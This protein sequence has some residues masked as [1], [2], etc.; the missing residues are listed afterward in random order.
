M[1]AGLVQHD[2]LQPD[3]PCH[4]VRASR[5]DA[6]AF[7]HY[8]WLGVPPAASQLPLWNCVHRWVLHFWQLQ[9]E[10][11]AAIKTVRT[12]TVQELTGWKE[13]LAETDQEGSAADG[14]AA[15][16]A[17]FNLTAERSGTSA[18][19]AGSSQQQQQ[20]AGHP[21][22]PGSAVQPKDPMFVTPRTSFSGDPRNRGRARWQSGAGSVCKDTK[23][24]F[25]GA[26][27][28][29]VGMTPVSA[30]P[31]NA[32]RTRSEGGAAP[33]SRG[34]LTPPAL[35]ASPAAAAA[36]AG[37]TPSRSAAEVVEARILAKIVS[38]CTPGPTANA[39]RKSMAAAAAAATTDSSGRPH[40][41]DR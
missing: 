22:T 31:G 13:P 15:A 7:E 1:E 39:V 6:D 37:S 14:E 20:Q 35:T 29:D 18:D 27:A 2:E 28:D 21:V 30:V 36:A 24:L 16:D 3:R 8:S 32:N 38:V 4:A 40:W 23:T 9:E 17:A 34:S 10:F 12:K 19:S 5:P 33:I 25:G 11:E 26:S 41:L